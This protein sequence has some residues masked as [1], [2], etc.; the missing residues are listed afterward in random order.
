MK[1]IVAVVLVV[2]IAVAWIWLQGDKERFDVVRANV[3][4]A[5]NELAAA[6][7]AV[8]QDFAR[9]KALPPP[10]EITVTSKNVRGIKLEADGRLVATLSFPDSP[11]ADGKHIVYEPRIAGGTLE[12][13]CHS[14]D[15]EKKYLPSACR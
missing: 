2:A 5:V 11:A 3:T 15:L 14:P 9:N 1:W 6:R 8:S 7:D 4:G 13:R 10:R 12:W